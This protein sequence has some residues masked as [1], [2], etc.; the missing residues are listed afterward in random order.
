[1]F[2]DGVQHGVLGIFVGFDVSA[3]RRVM[4][5]RRPISADKGDVVVEITRY[6]RYGVP[7]ASPSC[8]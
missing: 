5:A 2:G 8:H 3:W 1:M 4:T 7:N 6:A